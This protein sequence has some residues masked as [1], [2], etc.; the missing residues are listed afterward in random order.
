MDSSNNVC[1]SRCYHPGANQGAI[2]VPLKLKGLYSNGFLGLPFD[3]Q[4][5]EWLDE[6]ADRFL[7]LIRKEDPAARAGPCH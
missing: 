1:D 7:D 2:I 4:E 6:G 5:P 3:N